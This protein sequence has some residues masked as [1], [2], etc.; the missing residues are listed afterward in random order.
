MKQVL[1]YPGAKNRMA[2][3]IVSNIPNH[4]VY[5]EPFFGSGAVFFNKEECPIEIINDIDDDI[6]NYFSVLR[7]KP[8]ELIDLLHFTTYSRKEYDEAFL[9]D[10]KTTDVEKA[11]K[12]L[13]RCFMGFGASNRYKNGFRTSQQST[14]PRVTKIWNEFPERIKE[15]SF[16]L[17][18]AQIEHLDYKEI[19]ARYNTPDCFFYI[20]PPYLTNQRKKCIYKHEIDTSEHKRML[21][22][23]VNHPGRFL[24][25]SYENTLYNS[26]LKGWNKKLYINQVEGGLL[27]TEC[28]YAN[29]PLDENLFLF[30]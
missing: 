26:Y 21:E 18:N 8:N 20:D 19:L 10:D 13:V 15:A 9:I 29:Y 30:T 24:I 5:I 22:L 4:E 25:S 27:K 12:F 3:F 1:K 2:S 7:N 23:I 14:S 28:I 16:R 11:R 17:K 6:Y